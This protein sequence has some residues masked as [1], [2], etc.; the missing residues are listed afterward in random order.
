[1]VGLRRQLYPERPN[2]R[3]VGTSLEDL[4]WLDEVPINCPVLVLAEGALPYLDEADVK[5]L[6]NAVAQ[7]FPG[8]QLAFGYRF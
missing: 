6:L 1:M 3:L 8:G 5:A 7:H 2:C 4:Q